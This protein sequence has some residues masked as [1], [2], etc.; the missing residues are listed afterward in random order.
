MTLRPG[1]PFSMCCVYTTS[2]PCKYQS[3]SVLFVAWMRVL[4]SPSY[5]TL[6]NPRSAHS[7]IALLKALASAAQGTNRWLYHAHIET[8]GSP[9]E[10]LTIIPKPTFLFFLST[11]AFQFTKLSRFLP[12]GHISC[13]FVNEVFLGLLEL[14][15]V[16]YGCCYYL[17]WNV[18]M[19]FEN[20]C[21][22]SSLDFFSWA[23]LPDLAPLSLISQP[24]SA[25]ILKHFYLSSPI[26]AQVFFLLTTHH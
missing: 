16:F 26:F 22:S 7:S 3:S 14:L 15:Q 2:C 13:I 23:W 8:R 25:I 18:K 20:D 4:A 17:L 9:F 19:I 5:S 6:W 12:S 1:L 21:I 11:A 24:S 10:S